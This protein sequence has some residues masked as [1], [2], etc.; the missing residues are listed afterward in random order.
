VTDSALSNGE[1]TTFRNDVLA[2]K[3]DR[4]R[5]ILLGGLSH[6]SRVPLQRLRLDPGSKVLD[7]GCGWG[8]TAMELA[9]MVGPTGSVVGLDCCSS[10]LARARGDAKAA[11]ALGHH[12]AQTARAAAGGYSSTTSASG[13]STSV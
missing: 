13:K 2:P 6:H 3:F 9:G 11:G 12:R 10:F 4:F 5:S 7:V 8:D 1:V